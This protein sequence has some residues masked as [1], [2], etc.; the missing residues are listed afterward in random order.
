MKVYVQL[1]KKVKKRPQRPPQHATP[2]QIIQPQWKHRRRQWKIHHMLKRAKFCSRLMTRTSCSACRRH[3]D[4]HLPAVHPLRTKTE[5]RSHR[6][7][8]E[9]IRPTGAEDMRLLAVPHD[10]TRRRHTGLMG[11]ERS[12][13]GEEGRGTKPQSARGL[14]KITSGRSI[15]ASPWTE[16]R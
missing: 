12:S 8:R 11:S 4:L 3:L 7:S 6:E 1:D 5:G 9:K 2:L 14:F 10:V 16:P 15:I 13:E